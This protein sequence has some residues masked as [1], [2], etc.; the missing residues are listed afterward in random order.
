MFTGGAF[1]AQSPED[2]RRGVTDAD[3]REAVTS[4][5]AAG[6][7]V[8]LRISPYTEAGPA[9]LDIDFVLD[10]SALS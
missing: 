7:V 6:A 2:L 3:I 10:V 5:V 1:A 4:T 9:R 8:W